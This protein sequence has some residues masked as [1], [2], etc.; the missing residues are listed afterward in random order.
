MKALVFLSLVLVAC[1]GVVGGTDAGQD[2]AGADVAVADATD[3]VATADAGGDATDDA[4]GTVCGTD[5]QTGAGYYPDGGCNPSLPCP[6]EDGGLT[7]ICY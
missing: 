5:P 3:A 4:W 7:G 1:G 6:T 2:D